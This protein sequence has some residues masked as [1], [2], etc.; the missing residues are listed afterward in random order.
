MARASLTQRRVSQGRKPSR[1]LATVKHQYT[2]GKRFYTSLW[3]GVDYNFFGLGK[4]VKIY[5]TPTPT[6][7]LCDCPEIPCM[8]YAVYQ[9]SGIYC[10]SGANECNI[11]NAFNNPAIPRKWEHISLTFKSKCTQGRQAGSRPVHVQNTSKYFVH[12][13]KFG[14]SVFASKLQHVKCAIVCPH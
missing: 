9:K 14:T 3:C 2:S 4:E 11:M 8:V 10:A 1:Y 13:H 5:T 7:G 6:L 12:R